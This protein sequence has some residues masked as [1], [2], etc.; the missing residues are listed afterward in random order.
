MMSY[1]DRAH[2]VADGQMPSRPQA[3]VWRRR[4]ASVVVDELA[5]RIISGSL[6]AGA[7][8]PTE[9]ALCREFGFS[10]TVMREGL[11]LLEERRLLRVEQG[12][13][14]TV[15]PRERWNMLDSDVM[16][17]ALEYDDDLTLINDLVG[18][19]R[20][21]EG[22][23]TRDAAG[24]LAD[25]DLAA[26]A[27][28]IDQMAAAVDDFASFDALDHGF[29]RILMRASGSEVGSTIVAAIHENARDN[30]TIHGP[31]TVELNERS[32]AEHRSILDAL[33]ARDGELAAARMAAHIESA[34][35][36]RLRAF[37]SS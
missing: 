20:V 1:P 24:R 15:E 22:E 4:L 16:R 26:L 37:V 25:D 3:R 7:A 36:E 10:R 18:V 27:E 14:T 12:R 13:G 34:W 30:A 21:L 9:D 29:H 31:A 28:H 19:R 23:M 17:I 2:V 33:T 8:L 35:S 11:K 6:S 32:V 5:R